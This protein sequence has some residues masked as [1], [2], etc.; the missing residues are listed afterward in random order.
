MWYENQF[1]SHVS[2]VSSSELQQIKQRAFDKIKLNGFPSVK[3]ESWRYTDFTKLI[4][5]ELDVAITSSD[6]DVL[7]DLP[8]ELKNNPTTIFCSSSRFYLSP[9][10]KKIPGLSISINRLDCGDSVGIL[11]GNKENYFARFFPKLKLNDLMEFLDDLNVSLSRDILLITLEQNTQITEAIQIVHLNNLPKSASFPRISIQIGENSSLKLI[12]RALKSDESSFLAPMVH[13]NINKYGSLQSFNVLH[14]ANKGTY[15]GGIAVTQQA[16]SKFSNIQCVFGGKLVRS[17]LKIDLNGEHAESSI[18]GLSALKQ[19]QHCDDCTIVAHTVPNCTSKQL[20]KGIYND[21]AVGVFSG[22]INVYQDAQKTVAF[23]ANRNLLLSKNAT[24]NTRPQLRILA[25]DVK[26]T[27]GATVGYLDKNALFYLRSRGLSEPEAT[28]ILA[29]AF[30]IEVL[31]MIDELDL[32]D[33]LMAE[34]RSTL[35]L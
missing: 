9:E 10:F 13:S 33:K 25:D 23:Q 26:C 30:G 28:L 21:S 24:V 11:N 27:H 32:K 29:E 1:L 15:F 7:N 35:V 12:H 31:D 17:E 5:N 14:S 3:S 22:T 6:N 8:S 16:S 4:N 2:A 18:A 19:N 20:Y 34:F